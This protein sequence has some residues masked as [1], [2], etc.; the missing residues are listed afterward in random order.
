MAAD[1]TALSAIEQRD[2]IASGA[3]RV[4][5]LAEAYIA[6]IEALEPQVR[7]WA[8]CLLYTSDAADE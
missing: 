3:L 2:R 6:R 1:P 5:E 8:C 4:T 7:A